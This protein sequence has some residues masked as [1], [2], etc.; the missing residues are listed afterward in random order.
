MD[1]QELAHEREFPEREA[2]PERR[3]KLFAGASTT[4]YTKELRDQ[5]KDKKI[6]NISIRL[7]G[8]NI[9]VTIKQHLPPGQY[10]ALL[11]IVLKDTGEVPTLRHVGDDSSCDGGRM[12]VSFNPTPEWDAW[13]ANESLKRKREEDEERESKRRRDE[14]FAQ[15]AGPLSRKQWKEQNGAVNVCFL[16]GAYEVTCPDV[17]GERLFE[18]FVDE[19]LVQTSTEPLFTLEEEYKGK[20]I[21]VGLCMRTEDGSENAPAYSSEIVCA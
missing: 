7:K 13:C 9:L 20:F 11:D 21:I 10:G 1:E 4:T 8:S 19:Q 14:L 12:V 15:G 3:R 17:H 5:V 6:R 2:N 18:L 16:A